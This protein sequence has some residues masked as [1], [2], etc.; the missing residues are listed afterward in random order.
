MDR[1]IRLV[2]TDADPNIRRMAAYALGN[3]RNR[4]ATA[5]L[6]EVLRDR[7]EEGAVRGMA[8]EQLVYTKA[9]IPDLLKGLGDSSR[10]VRFWSA[11]ALGEGR[12]KAAVPAL[13]RL[14]RD[15]SRVQAVVGRA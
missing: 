9:A 4:R 12:V 7:G 3:I 14:T 1:L 15:R 13:R 2:R 10:E 5:A 11:Y 6:R 8:T